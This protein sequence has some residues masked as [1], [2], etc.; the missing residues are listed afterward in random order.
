MIHVTTPYL[1]LTPNYENQFRELSSACVKK[2]LNDNFE[3]WHHFKIKYPNYIISLYFIKKRGTLSLVIKGPTISKK[4]ETVDYSIFLPDEINNL[5]DY[6]NIIF[7]GVGK[8]LGKYSVG[9]KEIENMKNE[10]KKEL[11][12][13]G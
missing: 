5:E 3:N 13:L 4:Q 8:V 10:C 6:L 1:D 11:G 7:E 12:L 9:I 2:I